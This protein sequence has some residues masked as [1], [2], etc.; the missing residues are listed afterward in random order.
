METMFSYAKDQLEI[1]EIKDISMSQNEWGTVL[2]GS[3][4]F[5]FLTSFPSRALVVGQIRRQTSI[6]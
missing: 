2:K 5:S 4:Q 3:A 1:V 6:I